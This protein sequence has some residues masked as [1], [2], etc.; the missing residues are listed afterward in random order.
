MVAVLIGEVSRR[1]GVSVRMLRHYDAL[2][3]VRPSVRTTGGYRDYTGQDLRKLVRVEG[4]RSIGL[5]LADVADI[6][7][8]PAPSIATVLAE[9]S[10][11]VNDRIQRDRALLRQLRQLRAGDPGDTEELL[12]LLATIRALSSPHAGERFRASLDTS[13][14]LAADA[15]LAED[16]ENV[17]G[18]LRWALHSAGSEVLPQLIRGI[19]HADPQVR[20][21]TLTALSDIPGEDPLPF[22][23][24]CASDE[25]PVVRRRAVFALGRRGE[26]GV[27]D[28]LVGFIS[29]GPDDVEAAEILGPL[30]VGRESEVVQKLTGQAERAIR[31]RRVQALGEIPGSEAA[32]ALD[33]LSR[34]ADPHV[35][36][37]ARVVA[38]HRE[39]GP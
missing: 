15:L 26:T 1:T 38:T 3:L 9:L 34:D 32:S 35:A 17:A 13:G 6:L 33:R 22:L 11:Q 4:L 28:A 18:A 5:S 16:D 19:R 23:R 10:A 30:A 8:S 7:H 27:I 21:R 25:D 36:A 37:T 2:G 24:E 14:P 20:R 29:E 12:E 39:C 31:L